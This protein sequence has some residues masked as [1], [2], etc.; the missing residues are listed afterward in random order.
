MSPWRC[1][2]G[3]KAWARIPPGPSKGR[4]SPCQYL[5]FSDTAKNV[6]NRFKTLEIWFVTSTRIEFYMVL[7]LSGQPNQIQRSFLFRYI[8]LAPW[9]SCWF[10]PCFIKKKNNLKSYYW[11]TCILMLK[12]SCIWGS[13]GSMKLITLFSFFP[14]PLTSLLPCEVNADVSLAIV[15]LSES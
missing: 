15:D 13:S 1:V 2:L 8:F 3:K 6:Y 5:E 11:G 14:S 9:I 7:I 4:L 12:N 10:V